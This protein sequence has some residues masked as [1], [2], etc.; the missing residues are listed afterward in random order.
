[1][2]AAILVARDQPVG[3]GLI[4]L[5]RGVRRP[6]VGLE[7]PPEAI[8]LALGGRAV[9][10]L[11]EPLDVHPHRRL[12]AGDLHP[13]GLLLRLVRE[14]AADVVALADAA[15]PDHPDD[16]V[17]GQVLPRERLVAVHH[18]RHPVDHGEAREE[19]A[20]QHPA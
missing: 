15:H 7:E 19:T 11:V 18:A 4:D 17:V 2:G 12:G 8:P 10:E 14:E 1:M 20:R 5:G 16:G 3:H 6:V 13:V 9:E